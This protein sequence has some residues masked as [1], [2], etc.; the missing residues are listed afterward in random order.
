M[1][2]EYKLPIPFRELLKGYTAEIGF[3]GCIST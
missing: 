3:A 2:T 1:T